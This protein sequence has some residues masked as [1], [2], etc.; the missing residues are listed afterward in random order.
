MASNDGE[1]RWVVKRPCLCGGEKFS[2]LKERDEVFCER[3]GLMYKVASHRG[4]S[5]VQSWEF[6]KKDAD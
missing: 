3:C 1:C 6:V 5:P 4:K 2:A